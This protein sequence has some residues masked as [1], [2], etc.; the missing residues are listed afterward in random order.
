MVKFK[1][2]GKCWCGCGTDTGKERYFAAGH[3]KRAESLLLKILYGTENTVAAFVADYGFGPDKSLTDMAAD[4]GPNGLLKRKMRGPNDTEA[5]LSKKDLLQVAELIAEI[6]EHFEGG[7]NDPYEEYWFQENRAPERV[8]DEVV[9][10]A[11]EAGW[12]AVKHAGIVKIVRPDRGDRFAL[13][14]V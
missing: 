9:R 12:D 6:E 10:Q 4:P 7:N 8:W 11:Q 2:S 13:G 5:V 3:D 14:T 1:P